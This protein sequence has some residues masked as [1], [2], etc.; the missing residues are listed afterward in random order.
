MT[1]DGNDKN[2]SKDNKKNEK[3]TYT[4]NEALEASIKYFNDNEMAAR[5][6]LDK[7][8]LRNEKDEIVEK[9][10]ED[11]HWRIANEFARIEAKK[12]KKPLTAKQIFSYLDHFSKI[13]PQGSPMSGI[14]NPYQVV[15]L[16]NCFVLPS[17]LD[18]YAGICKTDEELV[19]ISKRRGGVGT[20]I[21]NLR[22]ANAPT[23]NAARTSTGTIPF[24]SRYSNS[25]REV[26][27]NGRRGAEMMTQSIH[28]PESV[29][30]WDPETDGEVFVTQIRDKDIGNFDISSVN[31]NPK[32][33]DF[34]T[35][36]YD[37]T[38]VTGANISLRLTD[39][40]LNAV[41][42]GEK[43]EQR[44]PIEK[45][46]NS[47]PSISK[48]VDARKVWDKIIY[49][50]WQTAEP[51]V[52]FWDNIIKESVADCYKDFGF[53]TLSTNPCGEI[54]LSAYDSCRLL[55]LNLFG[56]VKNP[57]TKDA[58]FD[59]KEF[60]ET[61]QIAQRLMDDLVDLEE[62]CILKIIQKVKSDPEPD[63]VKFRELNL[64]NN[65]LEA[66][67]SGR[68]TGTG[69]TALGDTI[70]A[71]NV[72]YG[73]KDGI[74]MTDRI[75]QTLKFACY[76]SSIDM[77]KELGAF[78]VW[79]HELEKDNPYLLRIKNEAL[80]LNDVYGK[81]TSLEDEKGQTITIINGHELWSEMKKYG[82][83]NIAL[84]T[85]APVGTMSNLAKLLSFYGTSS[86]I[87][88]E[89]DI[90][91]YTRKKKGNPG[92]QNFRSDS[93]D[94]NGDHWMHFEV[95]CSALKDWMQV[96][97]ETDYKKSPWF[98]NCANDLDWTLRVRLQAAA[99][100]HVDHSISSTVNLPNDVTVEKVKE[101]YETAWK[102]GCKGITVYRDGC[103]SGV[104]VRE[105][106]KKDVIAKTQPVRRPSSLPC[107]V[108][109]I[110]VKGTDY[111][112]MVG[113][114]KGE[115]YEVFAGANGFIERGVK[116]GEITKQSRGHYLAKLDDGSEVKNIAEYISDEEEAVTRLASTALRHG[117]DI[118][119]VTH[120]LEKVRGDMQ[121]FAKAMSRALKKYI[122][123][124]SKVAGESCAEC[125]G[126]LVRQEGCVKCS[127]CQWTKCS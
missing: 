43:Y 35:V 14:G 111:F 23:R 101:I 7:Y 30:L 123:D 56:F 124:G 47:P 38:K 78:P 74:N 1:V 112:V 118:N 33:P 120:Q 96:T 88:P 63:D 70:A 86:G 98:E 53:Q 66:C 108:H 84:L 29:I 26:G 6:F 72:G 65:V 8:A 71:C 127:I 42:T 59:Y 20:D 107:D 37:R 57:Y 22:P 114:Y 17:P 82:R 110:K 87:E 34:A 79:D 81:H 106:E 58:Y 104:L 54:P 93:V 73:T 25:I 39:E 126:N 100:K 21:A 32:K 113:K 102:A 105:Q 64:W 28:H 46:P 117:T 103:R 4:Y 18:S 62:E 69:I 27:Q 125:G 121:G 61:A 91:P 95:R 48:M 90:T 44:W 55:V 109:H 15:S 3:T 68:R 19:Q 16:S 12:F 36:K 119:F 60:Y 51:G 11:S 77:A 24:M 115:P 9:T 75:Y 49:S 89:F 92:D 13:I 83:R 2:I 10:P 31:Y 85:T 94:G 41:V 76:Q 80:V 45:N 52:L 5:I 97:G 40:F 50:A 116:T 67:R 122:P 99:Q